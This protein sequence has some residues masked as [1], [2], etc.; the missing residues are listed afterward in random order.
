MFVNFGEKEANHC[1]KLVRHL[2]EVGIN[3]ELYPDTAKMV[4]QMKYA[5][6]KKIAFVALVGSEEMN[7][8]IITVKNMNTGEQMKVIMDDLLHLL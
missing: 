4:K 2:R 5:D 8:G 1:L 6:A 7:S 3:A